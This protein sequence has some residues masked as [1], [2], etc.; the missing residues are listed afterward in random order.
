MRKKQPQSKKCKDPT[1]WFWNRIL[2]YAYEWR[3]LRKSH[4]CRFFEVNDTFF[5]YLNVFWWILS[6]GLKSWCT[7]NWL[8]WSNYQFLVQEKK[9]S[10]LLC[11]EKNWFFWA[12]KISI[13]NWTLNFSSS[14]SK[15]AKKITT[16]QKMQRPYIMI[17]KQ[18]IEI[19][20]WMK[21]TTKITCLSFFRSKWHFF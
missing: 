17:L 5:N 14:Y 6:T 13:K 9:Y 3:K 2:K 10:Q 18:N 16:I 15:N 4:V 20:P 8:C 11:T 12:K 1:S 19:R 7:K 21:K